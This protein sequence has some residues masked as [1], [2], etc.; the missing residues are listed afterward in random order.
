M[1]VLQRGT[2][3]FQSLHIFQSLLP[4]AQTQIRLSKYGDGDPDTVRE[5]R[6]VCVCCPGAIGW[7]AREEKTAHGDELQTWQETGN[8]A[9]T[10]GSA[11]GQRRTRTN[12]CARTNTRAP[13]L[14]ANLRVFSG[15]QKP[16][17]TTSERLCTNTQ[18]NPQNLTS[19]WVQVWWE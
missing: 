17:M 2:L 18:E 11:R 10:S 13:T 12:R 19:A 6:G 4:S 3:F 5:A 1:K 9:T 15:L 7:P 16:R 14:P 8:S